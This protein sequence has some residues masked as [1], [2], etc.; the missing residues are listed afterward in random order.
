MRMGQG[1]IAQI[2]MSPIKA[3]AMVIAMPVILEYCNPICL[4]CSS[5]DSL[6]E[7]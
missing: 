2:A 5:Q 6:N 3:G 4:F 7:H 1:D